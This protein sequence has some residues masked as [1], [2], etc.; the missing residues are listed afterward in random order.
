MVRDHLCCWELMKRE[1]SLQVLFQ[2]MNKL[3]HPVTSV[4]VPHSA[5]D[6]S[7]YFTSKV[8]NIRA[9]TANAPRANITCEEVP[10]FTGFHGV[11][12]EEV[13]LLISKSSNKQCELDP[14]PTWL[15]KELTDVL[16]PTI[17]D[18][19][20]ASFRQG[21][22]PDS[23]KHAIVRSLIKKPSLD[24][25][26]YRPISNL[27]FVSKIIERLVVNRVS[28]HTQQHSLLTECQSAYR[29]YQSTETAIAI[30][31]NDI[32]CAIDHGFVS[33][34]VLLDLSAA[35]DTVNHEVLMYILKDRF[36]IEHHELDWFRSYHSEH[37]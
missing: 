2:K 3:L 17:R 4:S 27:S 32:V 22:F 15:V 33:A 37:Q 14:I 24:L 21:K 23:H 12:V 35:F 25:Q 19:A 9:T 11:T 5:Q 13:S 18:M 34:L 28:D 26:S 10:L 20:D 8:D 7:T 29:Q 36:S 31:H 16:A 30:V 6:F 1:G